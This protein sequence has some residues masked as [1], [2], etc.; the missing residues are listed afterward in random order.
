M[1]PESSYKVADIV[2][3]VFNAFLVDDEH[4]KSFYDLVGF[5]LAWVTAKREELH[6]LLGKNYEQITYEELLALPDI[7]WTAPIS[8][9]VNITR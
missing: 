8:A 7:K 5:S 1:K 9:V 6:S 4:F 2:S 3:I